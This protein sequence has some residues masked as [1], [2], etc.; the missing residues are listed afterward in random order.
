M[1][2]YQ[3]LIVPKQ[4]NQDP[5]SMTKKDVK[6]YYD[7]FIS[8]KD[9]RLRM[10]NK[11]VFDTEEVELLVD[12][13]EKVSEFFSGNIA[14]RK[15][16]E[17]EISLE[18]EKLPNQLK[19]I[20]K[21]PDYELIEPTY[22]I[23][24]DVGIYFSEL[25]RKEIPGLEWGKSDKLKS[26]VSYGKPVLKKDGVFV[27]FFPQNIMHIAAMQMYKKTFKEGRML[28]LYQT[29]KDNFLGIK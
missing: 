10:F 2:E 13:L 16:S 8:I 3:L 21:V 15:L 27:T 9:E 18:R 25:L 20:H 4:I 6:I 17:E 7:W 5:A 1:K 22:S 11:A 23:M 14:A 26:D 12:N 28:E 24:F 29:W 19:T